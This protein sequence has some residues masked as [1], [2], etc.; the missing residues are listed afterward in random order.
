MSAREVVARAMVDLQGWR[1]E[2]V[3]QARWLEH[4]DAARVAMREHLAQVVPAENAT[5]DYSHT[6]AV[7][8]GWNA[9]RSEMLK[10]LGDE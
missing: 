1:W 6:V 3:D 4:A 9:C 8:G 7:K 5:G 10:A 2:R